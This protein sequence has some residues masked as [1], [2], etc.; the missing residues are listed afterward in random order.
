MCVW[1][2]RERERERQRELGGDRVME[3]EKRI[4]MIYSFRPLP[5]MKGCGWMT[6]HLTVHTIIVPM[7]QKKHQTNDDVLDWVLT[8]TV[9]LKYDTEML[10]SLR[11][12][13]TYT[14]GFLTIFSLVDA[15][16]RLNRKRHGHL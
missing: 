15:S 7:S 5:L 11:D 12:L 8:M 4:R 14:D 2:G 16:R 13:Y 3:K 9:C 1:G 10:R 6:Y